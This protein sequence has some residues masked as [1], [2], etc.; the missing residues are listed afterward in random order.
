V[1]RELFQDV[2]SHG[3]PISHKPDTFLH[4]IPP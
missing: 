2:E 3:R 4:A 1:L